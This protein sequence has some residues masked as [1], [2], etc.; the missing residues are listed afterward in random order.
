MTPGCRL[1]ATMAAWALTAAGAAGAAPADAGS[2]LPALEAAGAK[3]AA[4]GEATDAPAGARLV[5]SAVTEQRRLE[6]A[7]ALD[8]RA[9][10]WE[11]RRNPLFVPLT[12]DDA[13][14]LDKL[15]AV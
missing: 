5:L 14:E 4:G 2:Q 10:R 11:R 12:D 9:A 7:R 1:L 13:G 6:L 3:R 8:G 15:L